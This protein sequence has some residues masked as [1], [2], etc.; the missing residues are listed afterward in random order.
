M[1]ASKGKRE[2]V[3]RDDRCYFKIVK[4]LKKTS[5]IDIDQLNL[6]RSLRQDSL[7]ALPDLHGALRL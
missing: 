3:R 6:H 4:I 1:D 7:T 5:I 2:T